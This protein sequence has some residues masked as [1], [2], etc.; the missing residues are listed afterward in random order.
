MTFQPH[1]TY[2]AGGAG[3]TLTDVD[4]NEYL[5]FVNNFGSLIH[6]HAHPKIVAALGEQSVRG[7]D[8]GGPTESQITLVEM[9]CDRLPSLEQLRFTNSGTEAVL[10][11][12][13]AAR[14]YTGRPA[15]LKMEGGYHGGYDSVLVSVDPGTDTPAWPTG[16]PSGPGLP[17]S[18]T[19]D[20][21][22]APLNDLATARDLVMKH[23]HRLAAVI[24]EPVTIRGAIVAEDD[25]I[26][27][28][29]DLTLEA[30]VLLIIDEV[31]T[32]RLAR[33]G[34]QELAGVRPDLTTLGKIIGGG[35]PV[36]AFGGR[37]DIMA[38]F[39]P[40][41]ND[42]VHHSGTFAGNPL[43]VASSITALELFTSSEIR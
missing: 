10:Y 16:R 37:A 43:T 27:G 21:L 8:Y 4:G 19:E 2:M 35:L 1:P 11:A 18:V 5:D 42:P 30:G 23:R 33:G 29:R 3:C 7:T 24:V 40:H 22:V 14:A 31:V 15:I 28:L 38:R 32:F 36:G 12:I 20:T 26:R 34:A 17:P 25:F 9:L 41:G 13:R 6:G 39:D